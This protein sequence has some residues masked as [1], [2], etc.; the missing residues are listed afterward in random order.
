M[1]FGIPCRRT[2]SLTYNCV[3]FSIFQVSWIGIKWAYLISLSTITQMT[4][5]LEIDRGNPMMRSIEIESHFYVG[6]SNNL[7]S[8][9]S[10][11]SSSLI[12]WWVRHLST[13]SV[14]S[15]FILSYNKYCFRS[16]YIFGPPA[17][18]LISSI[19]SFC[20]YLLFQ[21]IIFVRH[22]WSIMESWCPII[23]YNESRRLSLSRFLLI[24]YNLA[25]SF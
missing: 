21:F 9:T 23:M 19:M 6:I 13:Y 22:T 2:T 11:W 12:L 4:F 24:M 18:T 16:V 1:S 5:L 20:Q 15:L 10:C 8:S 3:S 25:S 7:S 17:C 14:I